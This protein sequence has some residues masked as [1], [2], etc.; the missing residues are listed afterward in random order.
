MQS[1]HAAIIMDGNGRWAEARGWPRVR[2]HAAGAAALRKIVEAAPRL[3]VGTLTLYAF[4]SD[5]WQRPAAEVSALMQLLHAYLESERATLCREGVR[6][7]AIGRRDRLPQHVTAALEQT[8]AAT[9]AGA[10]LWLRLA[11]DY[12]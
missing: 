7:T 3:G 6:C 9:A 8:E 2:G 1:I 5:N 10:R 11:I 12:S 4:S